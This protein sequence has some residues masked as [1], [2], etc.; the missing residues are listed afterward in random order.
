[1][2]RICFSFG[3][4]LLVI[5]CS[6]PAITAPPDDANNSV[7]QVMHAVPDT[8]LAVP[9]F[10][11]D[12]ALGDIF[13][14]SNRQPLT[15]MTNVDGDAVIAVIDEEH[16]L[17][18]RPRRLGEAR[19]QVLASDSFQQEETIAFTVSIV[20]RPDD[21]PIREITCDAVLPPEGLA[22]FFPLR[23]GNT[24]TYEYDTRTRTPPAHFTR[25]NGTLTLSV[26]A[27][28][29]K[30]PIPRFI[31]Q[32]SHA[33]IFEYQNFAGE[34][35]PRNVEATRTF[36]VYVRDENIAL[37]YGD[38]PFA[39][40]HDAQAD[41]VTVSAGH[42][43]D[44]TIGS[45]RTCTTHGSDIQLVQNIGMVS[46]AGGCGRTSYS[47]N[48]NMSLMEATIQPAGDSPLLTF[49]P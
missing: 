37:W 38:R 11:L 17:H 5:G 9:G 15:F 13:S 39:R 7:I 26:E 22:D 14:H 16:V 40:Y 6:E 35:V 19:V 28:N 48:L 3:L 2:K 31:I 34:W 33:G 45:G 30:D 43:V 49:A 47:Y 4:L 44:T 32:E 25:E 27:E 36:V 23:A 46:Y 18:I 29:C 21:D 20:P 41:T 1:M 12:I 24:W 10:D 42:L 8:T